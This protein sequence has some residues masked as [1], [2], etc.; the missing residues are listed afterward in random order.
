MNNI[1]KVK[2]IRRKY[3]MTLQEI[4]AGM[5]AAGAEAIKGREF[6]DIF[7]EG[8]A[9]EIARTQWLDTQL[10]NWR[11]HEREVQI[12]CLQ[13][14]GREVPA[15]ATDEQILKIAEGI[16][17]CSCCGYEAPCSCDGWGQTQTLAEY[18]MSL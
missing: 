9:Y 17:T 16:M 1:D 14:Y 5:E 18:W 2:E 13:E 3:G 12:A 4:E 10:L 15:D 11:K 8:K 7:E 6:T